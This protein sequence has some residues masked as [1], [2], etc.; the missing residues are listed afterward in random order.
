MKIHQFSCYPGIVLSGAA[1]LILAISPGF[2]LWGNRLEALQHEDHQGI[3]A[4][5]AQ[6]TGQG[7]NITEQA[8]SRGW[9]P[10]EQW[11]VVV[12]PLQHGMDQKGQDDE[13][14]QHR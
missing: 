10:A 1:I 4:L 5:E 12:H 9:F 7:T 3:P 2:G 8:L 6:V 14:G 13:A 11:V